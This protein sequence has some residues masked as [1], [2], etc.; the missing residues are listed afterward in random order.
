MTTNSSVVLLER[1]TG[2]DLTAVGLNDI[3]LA[4]SSK[5]AI[6]SLVVIRCQ[7]ATAV[8]AVA[9]ASVITDAGGTIYASQTL[10]GFDQAGKRWAFP[11]GQGTHF[12]VTTGQTVR[13]SVD[14]AAVAS[15]ML[16]D[17]DVFGQEL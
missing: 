3:Y 1:H 4:P 11:T 17:V 8:T 7:T 14:T 16:V 13:L 9:D 10:T 12:I 6:I 15:A 2:I 5:R